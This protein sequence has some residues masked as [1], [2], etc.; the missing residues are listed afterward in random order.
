MIC[1]LLIKAFRWDE[2]ARPEDHIITSIPSTVDQALSILNLKGHT[3]TYAVCPICHCTYP[4]SYPPGA[5]E[6]IYPRVC[7]NISL[8]DAA[9]CGTELLDSKDQ[10]VRKFVYYS[11]HDYLAGLLSQPDIEKQMNA[12]CD[13]ALENLKDAPWGVNDIWEA[14]FLRSFEGPTTGSLFIDRKD[15]GRYVFALNVDFFNVNGITA[16]G[17][18]TSSGVIA[19]SC[20]NLPPEL[21]HKDG[22]MY[23]AGIIPDPQPKGIQLNYY[24][25]PVVDALE[26][27]WK[28]GV[29][30][31]K[32][33]LRPSG[34][35]TRSAVLCAVCDLV[36]ARHLTQFTAQGSHILCHV[37]R[38]HGLKNL[39]STNWTAWEKQDGAEMRKWAEAWR[40]GS[41]ESRKQLYKEHGL[42]WSELWRLPYWDLQRQLVVD[43]MHCFYE[44]LAHHYFRD[45]L[46]LTDTEAK[47]ATKVRP[48]FQYHFE[49]PAELVLKENEAKEVRLIHKHLV[50]PLNFASVDDVEKKKKTL[51]GYSRNALS[52]VINDLR[53]T[54]RIQG[55]SA[56]C[57]T[58]ADA[59]MAWVCLCLRVHFLY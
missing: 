48:A 3:T 36:G 51:S 50:A 53:C 32:T 12:A 40:T 27:S 16:R 59:L 9:E 33:A 2:V 22:Y 38:L 25:K 39:H 21:R 43:G 23:L 44:G 10:L 54:P 26:V 30:Y 52:F 7:S 19:M 15:E 28:K 35:L 24:L 58:M 5:K 13:D 55:K 41:R 49:E 56:T 6:A 29:F 14:E 18:S 47:E 37:C 34:I 20:L 45:Y 11:F 42:A 46:G 8:P 17:A 1:F 31:P 4:P 57:K